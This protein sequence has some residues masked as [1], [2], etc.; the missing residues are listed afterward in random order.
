MALARASPIASP[1]VVEGENRG[2]LVALARAGGESKMSL[3]VGV[4]ACFTFEC[5]V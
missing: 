5:A 1:I 4:S 2:L 3:G